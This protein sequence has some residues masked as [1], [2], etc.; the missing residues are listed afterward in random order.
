MLLSVMMYSQQ[1]TTLMMVKEIYSSSKGLTRMGWRLLG[2]GAWRVTTREG[3]AGV[4]VFCVCFCFSSDWTPRA[5]VRGSSLGPL[6]AV[7]CIGIAVVVRSVLVS[8]S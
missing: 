7:V 5:C 3:E 1:F 2:G 6:D 4:G 8:D